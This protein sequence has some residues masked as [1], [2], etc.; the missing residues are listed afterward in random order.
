[1]VTYISRK[2]I[3]NPQIFHL[4]SLLLFFLENIADLF[5]MFLISLW[6]KLMKRK[7]I[8]STIIITVC[9]NEVGEIRN[10]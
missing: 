5:L 1:M 6:L 3:V 7:M 4:F 10:P 9:S 2:V 8:N